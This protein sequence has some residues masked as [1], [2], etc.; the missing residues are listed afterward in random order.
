MFKGCLSESRSYCTLAILRRMVSCYGDASAQPLCALA[1]DIVRDAAERNRAASMLYLEVS[2]QGNA[3]SSFDIN[4]YKGGMLVSDAATRLRQ[5]GAS[6]QIP[7]QSIEAE[8]ARLGHCPLGTCS[9]A[10]TRQAV[11]NGV[12]R[13]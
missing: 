1:Q 12:R 5:A 7:E 6:F 13:S 8:L 3:R 11:P 9:L 4:L 10:W 2:E